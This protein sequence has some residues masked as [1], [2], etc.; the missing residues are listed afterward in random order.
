MMAACVT[1]DDWNGASVMT[2]NTSSAAK[3]ADSWRERNEPG[4]HIPDEEPDAICLIKWLGR[5]RGYSVVVHYDPEP[6]KANPF[7]LTI[8]YGFLNER[9]DTDDPVSVLAVWASRAGL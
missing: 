7:T 1:P 5:K 8:G 3:R 9:V 6:G 4:C 2:E